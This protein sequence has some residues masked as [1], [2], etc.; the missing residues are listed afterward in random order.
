[1]GNLLNE[2][3][4]PSFPHLCFVRDMACHCLKKI[5]SCKVNFLMHFSNTSNAALQCS[6]RSRGVSIMTNNTSTCCRHNHDPSL[7]SKTH[8]WQSFYVLTA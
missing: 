5:F 7:F 6:S 3:L 2:S 4:R 8:H 1:M